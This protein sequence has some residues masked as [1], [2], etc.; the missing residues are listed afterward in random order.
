VA[1]LTE[2]EARVRAAL[3]DVWSYEVFLDLTAE[4][5]GP[6]R[7][8]TEIRFGCREPGAATFAELGATATSAVLNGRAVGAAAGGR[9]ALP[10]LAAENTLVVEAEVA[11]DAFTRFADPA[12]GA[13]YLLFMGYPTQA[14]SV[15]CCFPDLAHDCPRRAPRF[16]SNIRRTRPIRV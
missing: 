2:T 7:S 15:F 9:L 12:D 1:A 16:S 5:A 13:D 4:P 3:L 6:A 14:P 11:G 10:E 8:R